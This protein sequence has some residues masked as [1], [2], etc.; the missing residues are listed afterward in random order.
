MSQR[1]DSPL[2]PPKYPIHDQ[3]KSKLR[4]AQNCWYKVYTWRL[5][6]PGA[7]IQ[8]GILM[9]FTPPDGVLFWQFIAFVYRWYMP[10]RQTFSA[11]FV[12][13]RMYLRLMC[14]AA[15]N[16]IVHFLLAQ[17]LF[18]C[19]NCRFKWILRLQALCT[20]SNLV[21]LFSFRCLW[22]CQLSYDSP[23]VRYFMRQT[24]MN[25][26]IPFFLCF[27]IVAYLNHAQLQFAINTSA[28]A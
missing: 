25:V 7:V 12:C 26:K 8:G 1:R 19:C 18:I 3:L 5:A 9:F 20:Y 14:K 17:K 10:L 27:F 2:F 15:W 16:M 13:V 4:R 23:Y 22:E 6:G 11:L 28:S 24:E 21:W